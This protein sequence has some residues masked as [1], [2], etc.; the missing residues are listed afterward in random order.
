MAFG[1]EDPKTAFLEKWE[2]SK[3]YLIE[4]AEAMPD[5]HYN[6]K[7]TARQKTFMEQL[8]HI[9]GNIDW[10]TNSYFNGPKME[11][12]SATNKKEIIEQ[13]NTSFENCYKYIKATKET[14]FR[15]TVT[16]FAGPKTKLQIINL[17]QDHVTHHRGQLI[18]YLN[19]K[20]I[21]PPKY[22]GW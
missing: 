7:P 17:L 4:I 1:Q 18:V 16:F 2:H 19:L 10:L 9:K 11:P 22:V 3:Q 6:F 13:L 15:E 12:A 14:S 20:D 5:E 21:T 8:K